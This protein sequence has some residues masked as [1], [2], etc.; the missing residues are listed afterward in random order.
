[1][2]GGDIHAAAL[3]G[4]IAAVRE[5]I[6]KR[7]DRM[8]AGGY[9]PL[10]LA[11]S[12]GHVEIVRLLLR[13]TVTVDAADDEGVT[14]LMHA[15]MHGYGALVDLLLLHGA[16]PL[17]TRNDGE[18]AHTLAALYGRPAA[19]GAFFRANGALVE[20]PNALG[21]TPLHNAVTL[22]HLITIKYLIGA[23]RADP[24][25]EDREGNS[26]LHL[27][28][29][30]VE[31]LVLLLHG[32]ASRPS[33]AASNLAGR[34]P[35]EE[36]AAAGASSGVVAAMREASK[37]EGSG[38]WLN[39]QNVDTR[40]LSFLAG[41]P[42][43]TP[44]KQLPDGPWFGQVRPALVVQ[45][46]VPYA[47]GITLAYSLPAGAALLVGA[48]LLAG[49]WSRLVRND[50]CRAGA[51]G[52]L[53]GCPELRHLL[54]L[55][56]SSSS[57]NG[58]RLDLRAPLGLVLAILFLMA[59]QALLVTPLLLP[60]RPLLSL[61]SYAAQAL[62]V[63]NY[64]HAVSTPPAMLPG[65]DAES[66]AAYWSALEGLPPNAG[67]PTD[68]C[69]RSERRK[70]ARARYSP[71]CGGMVHV[72][73]HDCVWIGTVV[74]ESNHP[75][76]VGFLLAAVAA[77]CLHL[78]CLATVQPDVILLLRSL[79]SGTPATFEARV[80][81]LSA[82]L[83]SLLLL[84]VL[85]LLI[86]HLWGAAFNVTTME[87]MRFKWEQPHI[88]PPWC[89]GPRNHWRLYSPYDA[90]VSAN[91]RH[92]LG[93]TR[94]QMPASSALAELP[95]A[96]SSASGDLEAGGGSSPDSTPDDSLAHVFSDRRTLLG[97]SRDD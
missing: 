40:L 74:C 22:R 35:P 15:A 18:S 31:A 88:P 36:A 17:K 70:V 58:G 42:L 79:L 65:A 10:G 91:V 52:L 12:A 38:A 87:S 78:A 96:T 2:A 29:G 80:L 33:L 44:P 53:Q 69:E 24:T 94:S 19:L 56:D 71:M 68:F 62:L 73:D 93:R 92:F 13:E 7:D 37:G 81:C 41:S 50:R 48:P 67:F 95:S 32:S 47:W 43:R 27:C 86:F 82:V 6:D 9:T 83:S 23:W 54:G 39:S 4:D 77:I 64:L 11:V 57:P 85:P 21:R 25:V 97:S 60:Q 75:A 8:E 72:M 45:S 28:R 89:C 55:S 1:M 49:W 51:E 76:F 3:Q 59:T 63:Y 5:L 34:T 84:G 30:P 20:T 66:A 14:A 46:L 26:P 90:G 61:A 16:S